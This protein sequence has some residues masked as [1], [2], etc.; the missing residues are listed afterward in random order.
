MNASTDN[1]ELF[2]TAGRMAADRVGA[3]VRRNGRPAFPEP[4]DQVVAVA[5]LNHIDRDD[6]QRKMKLPF[7]EEIARDWDL[8]LADYILVSRRGDGSLWVIDGQ[9]RVAAATLAGET[10][11]LA[12]VFDGLTIEQEADMFYTHAVGRRGI[13][14]LEKFHSGVSAK[15]P[16]KVEIAEIVERV[17]ARVNRSPNAASGINSPSTLEKVVRFGGPQLLERALRFIDEVSDDGIKGVWAEGPTVA[18]ITFMLGLYGD[19]LDEKHL[20]KRLKRKGPEG[21]KDDARGYEARMTREAARFQ[22]MVDTYNHR[23]SEDRKLE[24][25]RPDMRKLAPKTCTRGNCKRKHHARGLCRPHYEA[26]YD[27]KRLKDVSRSRAA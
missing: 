8:V 22:A 14:S 23:I 13:N 1:N 4:K 12:R 16:D 18:G 6:Y 2:G 7:V 19:D 21:L 24:L 15:Y 17:G 27:Q 9:H 25:V 20:K 5:D 11:M 3:T 10:M 26:W